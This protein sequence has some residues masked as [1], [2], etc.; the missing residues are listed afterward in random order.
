MKKLLLASVSVVMLAMPALA[1]DLG[2]RPTY[3]APPAVAPPVP[4]FTW[5][6]CYIGGQWGRLVGAQSLDRCPQRS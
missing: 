1:A 3:K 2:T 5:T 6:G 4:V